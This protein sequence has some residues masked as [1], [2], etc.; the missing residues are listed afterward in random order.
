MSAYS[1]VTYYLDNKIYFVQGIVGFMSP[2]VEIETKEE[3]TVS[4]LQVDQITNS[5][6]K[7][8]WKP[9]NQRRPQPV[10]NYEVRKSV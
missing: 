1:E 10:C 8:S 2:T 9:N 3:H 6:I 7:V 4:L 5:S